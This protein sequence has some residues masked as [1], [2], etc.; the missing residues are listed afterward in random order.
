MPWLPAVPPFCDGGASEDG[1]ARGCADAAHS[2]VLARRG[3][4]DAARSFPIL[5]D[6]DSRAASPERPVGGA[7]PGVETSTAW[8]SPAWFA[9]VVAEAEAASLA[10]SRLATLLAWREPRASARALA[11]GLYAILAA[12]RAAAALAALRPVTLAAAGLLALLAAEHLREHLPAA[13]A[14]LSAQRL[15]PGLAAMVRARSLPHASAAV[16]PAC[17]PR[18]APYKRARLS[19]LP[20]S[21]L[22]NPAA[23][24]AMVGTRKAGAASILLASSAPLPVQL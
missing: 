6:A 1:L 17:S 22:M 5:F 14:L 2:R 11:I 13:R 12:R 18:H 4:G 21:P 16:L 7:E 24:A 9:G 20:A 19:I 23:L 15:A 8:R 3:D 10:A